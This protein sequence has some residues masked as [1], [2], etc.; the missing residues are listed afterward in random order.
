MKVLFIHDNIPDYLCAGLFHGLRSILGTNCL[1]LPRFDCMYKTMSEGTKSKIR[2]NAFSLYG[3]LDE[4]SEL[5]ND[6]FF[7]WHK[8]IHEFD[9]YIIADIWNCWPTYMR[10]SK[11]VDAKKIIIIDPSDSLRLFPFNNFRS[12]L[13]IVIL[14]L[15]NGISS[16]SKYFKRE[17]SG[18]KSDQFGFP[19]FISNAL[20]FLFSRNTLYPISFSIPEEKIT[21]VTIKEKT[22]LFTKVIVDEEFDNF[23]SS[24]VILPLNDTKYHF[25]DEASYYK[26]IQISKFG[27]TM[28]R[29]G[30]DCLRHYEYAA[31]GT[32]LCF[33]Q[34]DKKHIA[35]APHD[36]ISSNCIMYNDKDE[37][38][39]KINQINDIQY[40]S[41]LN[42]TYNWIQSKTTVSI[43]KKFLAEIVK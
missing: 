42:N 4:S 20:S 6:R 23:N 25:T 7:I 36:L 34:L 33:K 38:L 3:L 37:L 27:I 18:F 1:D 41:L 31:N 21:R 16:K 30:W 10:L 9:Y 2:G 24:S 13:K 28:K 39:Y 40:E 29:A 26:D 11:L 8:N 5:V 43:A 14:N 32:V 19:D 15:I 17:I 35:C 12:D 22:Q